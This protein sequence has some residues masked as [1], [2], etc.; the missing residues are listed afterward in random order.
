MKG[1]YR[2]VILLEERPLVTNVIRW[3]DPWDVSSHKFLKRVPRQTA[4]I[5][6]DCKG[7]Q[8]V[9]LMIRLACCIYLYKT[10]HSTNI[11]LEVEICTVIVT[12]RLIYDP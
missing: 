5:G 10:K 6:M 4:V 2:S 11:A 1:T 9:E 3:D 12:D 8:S 7:K